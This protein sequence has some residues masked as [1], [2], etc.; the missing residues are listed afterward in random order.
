MA[1]CERPEAPGYHL[2]QLVADAR[3]IAYVAHGRQGSPPVRKINSRCYP[4]QVAEKLLDRGSPCTGMHGRPEPGRAVPQGC[5]VAPCLGGRGLGTRDQGRGIGGRS[6]DSCLQPLSS[7]EAKPPDSLRLVPEAFNRPNQPTEPIEPINRIQ[8]LRHPRNT[9]TW[10]H[11]LCPL[12]HALR[13]APCFTD[14][15]GSRGSLLRHHEKEF[16][17][18][19]LRTS[20]EG[21]RQ[22]QAVG[23]TADKIG[24]QQ[25]LLVVGEG[26]LLT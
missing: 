24:I 8:P 2:P 21:V 26:H 4:Q 10:P 20:V 5:I 6:P 14:Q 3:G 12:P 1:G 11:A 7:G 15:P 25:L 22:A 13:L 23:R 17:S 18:N 19:L 9:C 16:F